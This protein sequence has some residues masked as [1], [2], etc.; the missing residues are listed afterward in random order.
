MCFY[1]I[2]ILQSIGLGLHF[3]NNLISCEWLTNPIKSWTGDDFAKL[4]RCNVLFQHKNPDFSSIA[5]KALSH[6]IEYFTAKKSLFWEYIHPNISHYIINIHIDA[7][8]DELSK[9]NGL[10]FIITTNQRH[11][12]F[13]ELLSEPKLIPQSMLRLMLLILLWNI[14]SPKIGNQIKSFLIAVATFK[15]LETST[16]ACHRGMR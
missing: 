8:W 4:F 3:L 10:G 14:A 13:L 6:T 9:N 2:N 5:L 7:S 1:W 16:N 11:V 15:W 12:R